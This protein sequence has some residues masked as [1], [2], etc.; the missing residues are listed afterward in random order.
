MFFCIACSFSW[1]ERPLWRHQGWCDAAG[2]PGSSLW[3]KTGEPRG[4]FLSMWLGCPLQTHHI[5]RACR[6][7]HFLNQHMPSCHSSPLKL[8]WCQTSGILFAS[9]FIQPYRAADGNV[10]LA[11]TPRKRLIDLLVLGCLNCIGKPRLTR[12]DQSSHTTQRHFK[13]FTGPVLLK[14]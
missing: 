11:P 4:L 9:L 3:T 2:P 13:D 5:L 1:G 8:I 10:K 7:K 12:T 6:I 14:V